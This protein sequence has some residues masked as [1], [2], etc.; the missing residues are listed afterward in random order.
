VDP[1]KLQLDDIFCTVIEMASPE[2]RAAYLDRVCSDD[3]DLRR[4]VER[5]LAA[6]SQAGSFLGARPAVSAAT[7]DVLGESPGLVIGQYKLLQVIG[8]GGMGTVWMAEQLQP[9]QRKVAL[10]IIKA[11]MD[12]H[13]VLARFEAERQALALMDHPNIAK[14][15]DAG[16]TAGGRP[17]F[18]MELVKGDS[19][20]RYCDEHRVTPRERLELFM[21]VCQAIQ[22]AH[23]K[24]IIHRDI[25]PSNVLVAPYDGKPVVKVIDF[26]VAKATGQRLTEKT[27]FT[28]FGAVVGTLEYMS[29]EQAELNNQD[30]DTRSDIY[31]LGVLLY[32]LLT[33]STPL[34]R[35]R[36]K[37]AAMMEVLRLI[38]EEEP[39]R[40]STRLS[41]TDELPSVAAKRGVEPK[42]LSVLVRGDLDWIAMKAL[43]KDRNRRY[44]TANGL[45]MDVQ[46]YLADEPVQACPPSAAYRFRKMVRRHKGQ[47]TAVATILALL[48]AGSAISTWQ[49]V[50]ATYAERET[51]N[52]LAQ[53]TA[54]QAKTQAA[55]TA[56]TAAKEE[57]REAMDALTGDVVETLF[58]TQQQVSETERKFL[59]KV[60]GIYEAFT[61]KSAETAEARFLRA[62][63]YFTV[64]RL[65]AILGENPDAVAGFRQA[66]ALLEKL[67]DE[68]P[69]VAEY[70]QK[71]AR[72]EGNMGI[73]LGKL[74]KE[75][76]A[77]TAFR[78]G[79]TLQT[80]L[81]GDSPKQPEY[82]KELARNYTSLGFLRELQH[83]Y[84][85]AEQHYRRALDLKERLIADFGAT[86][87]ELELVTSLMNMSQLLRK[88]E[89]Y[90]DSEKMG[91]RALKLQEEQMAKV[92]PTGRDRQQLARSYSGLGIALAEL[93]RDAEAESALRQAQ[94]V[95]RKLADDYPR[96][97]AYRMELAN[98]IG[99]L[100]HFLT[101]QKKIAAAVEQYSQVV[102]LRKAIVAQDATIPG[103]RVQL[104]GSYH[105]LAWALSVTHRPKEAE[106]NWRAARDLWEKL[107]AEMPMV[108]DIQNGLGGS[109]ANLAD[110]HNK[111]REFADAVVLL[112]KARTH[113][114][115]ALK[116]RPKDP[117]FRDFQR[118]Y[119]V[120]LAHTRLGL[121]D[122]VRAATTAAELAAFGFEPPK[123]TYEAA[124]VVSRC[125]PLAEKD[126][127]LPEAK[128]KELAQ[129][130]SQ[131]A[132]TL[133]RQAVKRGFTDAAHMQKDSDLDP[134]R[135]REEF[136]KLLSELEGKDKR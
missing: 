113:L 81:A 110:L 37:Q 26:G 69:D 60:V 91:R 92:P 46:R 21:P 105:D 51:A 124:C 80:K 54:E 97:L 122:H 133:L 61:Q 132:L 90:A 82:Q 95:R 30:I 13:G 101:R 109:L 49:G 48:L 65:R 19:I 130:Y 100:A 77:E 75:A 117:S 10:K 85:E 14:V 33:G 31:S 121:A 40:P 59:R 87:H 56:E 8:E 17:Y 134:L 62:K 128:R 63:G 11:G 108:P 45:A 39:P 36:L 42:K 18:V 118:D 9:V 35:N 23:Q 5:L 24:G 120:T 12:S 104:A 2:E 74:R 129:T 94:D 136:K 111:R 43:D 57:T 47:V 16:A 106:V 116:A 1:A 53:V 96:V 102:E 66:E 58:T 3:I 99:D 86:P 28:E 67:A 34:Q 7:Q 73:A 115:A 50:R 29:P 76:E 55:L 112:D 44:E 98:A 27:L 119:L 25:K 79:I 123:D 127:S 131:Q 135:G 15:L 126:M 89:K 83:K 114:Q 84:E 103:Y 22:H 68:F 20:T 41:T 6:H 38:R 70:R 78:R 32:E 125:V 52:A 93:K 4:R 72:T 71:L 64:A 107:A 88:Q